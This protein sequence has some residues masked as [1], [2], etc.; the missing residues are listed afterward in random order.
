MRFILLSTIAGMMGLTA[1]AATIGQELITPASGSNGNSN[2]LEYGFQLNGFDLDQEA[3]DIQLDSSAYLT[4]LDAMA[5]PGYTA[6]VLPGNSAG[7]PF[8]LLLEGPAAPLGTFSV[9]FTLSGTGQTGPLN[10]LVYSVDGN[11]N[12]SNNPIGSGMTTV[13]I[14]GAATPEPVTVRLILVAAAALCGLRRRA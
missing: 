2:E 10:Y 11:G 3:V 14:A 7:E 1:N 9:N 8:D 12:F 13:E 5:P 6:L 4:V